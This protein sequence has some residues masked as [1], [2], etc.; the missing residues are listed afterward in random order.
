MLLVLA[1]YDPANTGPLF[2]NGPM[3]VLLKEELLK[4]NFSYICL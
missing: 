1:M 2:T 4:I 3:P